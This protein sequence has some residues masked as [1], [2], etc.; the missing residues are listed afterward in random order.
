MAP[1]DEKALKKDRKY[2]MKLKYLKRLNELVLLY[3]SSLENQVTATTKLI[4][5]SYGKTTK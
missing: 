4:E 2:L 1:I 3:N 5:R